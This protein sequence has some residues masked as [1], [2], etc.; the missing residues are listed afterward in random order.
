MQNATH[1]FRRE[2]F[3]H[4]LFNVFQNIEKPTGLKK[5]VYIFLTKLYKL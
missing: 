4:H 3:L 1:S 5:N 2:K